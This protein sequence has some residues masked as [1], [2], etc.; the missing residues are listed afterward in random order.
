MA[1]YKR[2]KTW[3]ADFSVNGQ[4]YRASLD[5][6]DWREAQGKQKELISQ[7]S[8][9]KLAPLS[10]QFARLGFSEAADHFLADRLTH[11]APRSIQTEKERLKPLKA[12]F[13][14]MH[15]MRISPELIQQYVA[16]RKALDVSNKTVNLEVAIVRGILKR[17]RRWHLISDQ[18]RPL[19]VRPSGRSCTL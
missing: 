15:L 7:A 8:Q 9:G 16:Q 3:W 13:G 1:L 10:Q 17:A 11:L 6:S 4:R 14:A 19:P 12:Y 18:V 2:G 5:T